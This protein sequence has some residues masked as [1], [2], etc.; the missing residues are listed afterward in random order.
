[1]ASDVGNVALATRDS[2]EKTFQDGDTSI[3][4]ETLSAHNGTRK[5][6]DGVQHRILTLEAMEAGND[7]IG[8][9]GHEQNSD[10]RNGESDC[11]IGMQSEFHK[12]ACGLPCSTAKPTEKQ[13]KSEPLEKDIV[14]VDCDEISTTVKSEC[15]DVSK[16]ES[17]RHK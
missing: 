11:G 9:E 14:V 10:A 4:Y 1:M 6:L 2:V 15:S 8:D 3:E 13:I 7:V 17:K 16:S 5:N 12:D